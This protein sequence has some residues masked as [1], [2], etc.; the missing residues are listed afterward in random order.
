MGRYLNREALKWTL[1]YSSAP[2]DQ[3]EIQKEISKT[4]YKERWLMDLKDNMDRIKEIMS[5]LEDA[6]I[7]RPEIIGALYSGSIGRGDYDEHSDIDLYTVVKDEDYDKIFPQMPAWMAEVGEIKY[8]INRSHCN[9][10]V[11][12]IDD[13]WAKVD[14]AVY[15]RSELKPKFEYRGIK[16][17]KDHEGLLA[18][19]QKLSID[20]PSD[21]PK[22]HFHGWLNEC[23]DGQIYTARHCARGWIMSAVGEAAY[24]GEQL[25]YL[26]LKLRG[27]PEQYGFRD[28]EN[29]LS[30]KEFQML[31]AT[32]PKEATI[33]AV[34][35]GMKAVWKLLKHVETEYERVV[36]EPVGIKC[37]DEELLAVAEKIYE[38]IEGQ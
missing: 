9:S 2:I 3:E 6:I 23:R 5:R 30:D 16:I 21:I 11:F 4:I 10:W 19:V 15:K 32:R 14:V 28:A 35:E 18:E 31:L 37:D 22:N 36:G 8:R 7:P 26:L 20:L 34:R 17:V 38:S 29:I 13:D 25:F 27:T 12:F 24:E 33:L 1:S